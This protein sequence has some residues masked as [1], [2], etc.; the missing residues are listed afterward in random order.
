MRLMLMLLLVSLQTPAQDTSAVRKPTAAV[1][2][3]RALTMMKQEEVITL[4]NKFRAS[5]GETGR[6][7]LL[8][9]TDMEAI[10]KEQD[11][12]LSDLCNTAECAVQ[13]GQLLA[14]E[15]IVVG[16]L[17]KVGTSYTV[18]VRIIDVSSGKVE[19]TASQEYQ[20]PSE[21]LIQT[22]DVL[23]QKLSGRY[24]RRNSLWYVLGGAAIAGGTAAAVLMLGSQSS[25]SPKVGR[26]PGTPQVP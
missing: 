24:R 4:T 10:L 22:C 20:G 19:R 17:G 6:F 3:F 14:A 8:E 13:V 11:F 18:T 25:T 26:P 12:S 2:D 9:R 16:D 23:A 21:G 5:L 15:K 1:L 7:T